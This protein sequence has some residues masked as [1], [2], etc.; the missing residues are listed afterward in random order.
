[1]SRIGTVHVFCA[2]RLSSRRAG[3]PELFLLVQNPNPTRESLLYS[4][5]TSTG[6]RSAER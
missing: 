6:R 5:A 1:M 2:E 3:L 4:P